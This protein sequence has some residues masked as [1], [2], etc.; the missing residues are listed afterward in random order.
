MNIKN[1][2]LIIACGIIG[3]SFAEV[4]AE[5]VVKKTE[6]N[7]SDYSHLINITKNQEKIGESFIEIKDQDR[8][9]RLMDYP[10]SKNYIN[11]ILTNRIEKDDLE[12]EMLKIKK[13]IY[14]IELEIKKTKL[15]KELELEK[16]KEINVMNIK[17]NNL[18]KES[19]KTILKESENLIEEEKKL[20]EEANNLLNSNKESEKK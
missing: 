16:Y 14:L 2:L 12:L 8:T 5:N 13:E 6:Y 17:E 10:E 11:K 3:F 20:V 15:N 7:V 18:L 4:K 19:A 1:S 9:L